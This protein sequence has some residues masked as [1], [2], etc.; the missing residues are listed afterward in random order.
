MSC[1]KRLLSS[2]TRRKN[3]IL[4]LMPALPSL[5]FHLLYTRNTH[6]CTHASRFFSCF[7][8]VH[9]IIL[10]LQKTSRHLHSRRKRVSTN[11]GF[12]NVS[13]KLILHYA[14]RDRRRRRSRNASHQGASASVLA[15]NHTQHR[16][17][18]EKHM[19]NNLTDTTHTH[20]HTT[21]T[22]RYIG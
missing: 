15:V 17:R 18:F 7:F 20:I 16:E 6:T 4:G 11:G 12:L 10:I 8:K 9:T 19:E 1:L 22:H 3:A 13:Q 5:L 2:F 14:Q 21:E